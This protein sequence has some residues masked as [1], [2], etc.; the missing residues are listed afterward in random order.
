MLVPTRQPMKIIQTQAKAQFTE[1]LLTFVGTELVP[2]F[3]I[4]C[5]WLV[6]VSRVAGTPARMSLLGSS[7]MKVGRDDEEKGEEGRCKSGVKSAD[8][9]LEDDT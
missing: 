1:R 3:P 5:C 9:S 6:D 8:R 2:L 4:E 7:M